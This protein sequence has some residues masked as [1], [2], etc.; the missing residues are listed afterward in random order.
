EFAELVHELPEFVTGLIRIARVGRS[1][2]V[3]LILAT[4]RPSGVVSPEMRSN[5][6]L[7]VALRME[8]KEGS[9]E[10]LGAPHA[11]AISRSNPGRGFVRASAGMPVEFQTARV[12]GRRKGAI[13][14]LA[15]PRVERVPWNRL[16]Y[17]SGVAAPSEEA[18]GTATDLDA[19]VDL[20]EEAARRLEIPRPPSPWLAALPRLFLLPSEPN[21]ASD[22]DIPPVPFGLEDVPSRQ[23]QRLAEF[24][25]D[26][27]GHLLV[28]GSPRSGRS[29]ALRTL[30]GALA[31]SI[32][33]S[34]LH[35]YAL[36]FG[37][38]ALLPLADLPHCGAV[39]SRSEADR[40]ERLVDWLQEEMARRQEIL[41]RGGFGDIGEQ[42]RRVAATERL[43]YVV[44]FLDRFEGFSAQFPPDSGSSIPGA[45]SR[46]VREGGGAGLRLVIA[47]DRGLLG[48]RLGSL[49]EDKLVLRLADR[50]D[51]RSAGISP[52]AVPDEVPPGRAFRSESGIE[53][54]LALLEEDSSGLAQAA[55]LRHIG[56]QAQERWPLEERTNR[57]RRVDLLPSAIGFAAATALPPSTSARSP[58]WALVGVGG[59]ELARFGVDL[60]V[61]A[62]FVVAGPSRSG[63]SGALVVMARSLAAQGVQVVALCPRLSPLEGLTGGGSDFP[64]AAVRVFSGESGQLD[65]TEISATL[66]RLQGP[67]AV[68]VDD[69]EALAR[70]PVDEAVRDFVRS[71][72]RGRVGLVVAGMADELRNELKGVASEAKK[73]RCALL[74]SPS[75]TLDGDLV[76]VRLPRNLVG[77]MPA[78]RGVLVAGAQLTMVQVP[79]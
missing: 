22:V 67:V 62:G 12:A 6:G 44:V 57:P 20:I 10:V 21:G 38:G 63:R 47:G 13:V 53:V 65:P 16:G 52:K 72:S 2:G 68:L 39:V 7:R 76:G 8:D 30:A 77:R 31:R 37:N 27:G 3:H 58:L 28:A 32:S 74:L 14:G 4:Q 78:G 5:T 26:Q 60:S 9:T 69:A 70:G 18:P 71:A 75:S 64:A 49:V 25:L 56:R 79:N 54:Q 23:L 50:D 40:I 11:A 45:L 33:P 36:D 46:L 35:L 48:D 61:D 17:P 29:S 59:D 43:P 34:D 41:A 42:R 51:Y 19:L 1:L 15:P 73:A 24:D 55:A 66:V